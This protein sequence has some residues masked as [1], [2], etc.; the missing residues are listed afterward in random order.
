MELSVKRRLPCNFCRKWSRPQEF[1]R[2]TQVWLSLENKN[3]YCFILALIFLERII[4]F[5]KVDLLGKAASVLVWLYWF[6][7]CPGDISWALVL[8]RGICGL[9]PDPEVGRPRVAA[10]LRCSAISIYSQKSQSG[11]GPLGPYLKDQGLEI[12]WSSVL[13]LITPEVGW[14]RQIRT[15][16]GGRYDR[17]W[18]CSWENLHCYLDWFLPLS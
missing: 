11:S 7:K 10:S 3:E 6:K 9:K 2:K 5:S 18:A 4:V 1:Q 13:R 12:S 17:W 15:P 16:M 8:P 14:W